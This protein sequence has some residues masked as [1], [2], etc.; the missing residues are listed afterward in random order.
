VILIWWV[1]HWFSETERRLGSRI[2]ARRLLGAALLT[3]AIFLVLG[4]F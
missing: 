1:G 3:T 4:R 2:L